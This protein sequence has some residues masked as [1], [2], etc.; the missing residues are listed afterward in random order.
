MWSK[1]AL[2]LLLVTSGWFAFDRA[3]WRVFLCVV[4][5]AG[6]WS[7]F[8]FLLVEESG[9]NIVRLSNLNFCAQNL[10]MFA[11]VAFCKTSPSLMSR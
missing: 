8:V 5:A 6:F 1:N 10:H 3:V 4:A 7:V 11:R 9:A 2:M